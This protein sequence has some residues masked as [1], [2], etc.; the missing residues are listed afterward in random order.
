MIDDRQCQAVIAENRLNAV[1][2][3]VRDLNSAILG[4]NGVES[5]GNASRDVSEPSEPIVVIKT[6]GDIVS[7]HQGVSSEHSSSKRSNDTDP[8]VT[9]QE[10]PEDLMDVECEL[11]ETEGEMLLVK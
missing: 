8:L 3:A 1:D 5:N 6:E 2:S 4:K 9:T 7:D 11:E 10:P